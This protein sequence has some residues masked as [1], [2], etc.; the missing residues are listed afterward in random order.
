VKKFDEKAIFSTASSMEDGRRCTLCLAPKDDDCGNQTM[1]GRGR[2]T[3]RKV[4]KGGK[5]S[6][7]E[8]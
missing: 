4:S 8:R 5:I 6:I 3:Q 7:E 2:C 1:G